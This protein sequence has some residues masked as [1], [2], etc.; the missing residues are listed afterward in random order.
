MVESI[1]HNVFVCIFSSSKINENI[2]NNKEERKIPRTTKKNK[3][4][5][6]KQNHKEI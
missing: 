6:E 3:E 1:S 5:E 2:K 4:E